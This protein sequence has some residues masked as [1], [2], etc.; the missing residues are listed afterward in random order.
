MV[1]W[2]VSRHPEWDQMHL[3]SL[4]AREI[5]DLCHRGAATIHYHLQRREH[6]EPGFRGKHE[7][8]LAVR[9]PD[10]PTVR[11]RKKLA[12]VLEFQKT[13][14]RLPHHDGEEAESRMHRWVLE[15][16]RAHRNNSMSI[17]KS[18]LLEDLTGWNID[19]HQQELDEAWRARLT[20]L[21]EFA[22]TYHRT[23]R[24]QNYSSEAERILG[25]WLHVQ[26]QRR[27]EGTMLPWRLEMMD[28]AFLHWQ[29]RM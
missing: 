15:Q 3:A 20:S 27:A 2:K 10:R 29:S 16:R 1:S 4:T 7:A 14:S 12:E 9:G 13:H 25:V 6:Y 28:T 8:A 17:P 5:T 11:W 22:A 23:P 19:V 24:Y 18:V 26:H 21:I